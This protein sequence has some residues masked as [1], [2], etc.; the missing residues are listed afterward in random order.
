[1]IRILLLL[2]ISLQLFAIVT[3]KPREVGEKPGISGSVSGSFETK[4]G[5]TDKDNYAAA[6]QL[7]YD[8]NS[9]YLVWGM[10]DGAYGESSGVTDTNELY[11]HLRYIRNIRGKWLAYEVFSQLEEDEFKAIKDRILFGADYRI[12]LMR[13]KGEWGGLFVGLGAML[14]YIGYTTSVDPAERNVRLNSYL[15]Y[16]LVFNSDSRFVLNGYYQPKIDDFSDYIVTLAGE[17]EVRIYKQLFI[18]ITSTYA[19]DSKPAVGVKE[20]D[21]SQRTFFELKF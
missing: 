3:I 2:L 9:T 7:Q 15:S 19:H 5:N 14:E 6:L 4:R 17:L 8:S 11:G 21:F 20:D 1:L 10:V 18:G 13:P 16:S 12:K